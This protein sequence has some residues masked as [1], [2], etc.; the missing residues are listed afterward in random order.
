MPKLQI[1]MLKFFL[2]NFGLENLV[3]DPTC[4][5]SNKNPRLI[6]LIITNKKKCIRLILS[7]IH[8]PPAVFLR[9][10]SD[11]DPKI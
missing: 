3:N 2:L 8:T 11:S 5:K 7:I 1:H 4:F 9:A 10:P 6:D